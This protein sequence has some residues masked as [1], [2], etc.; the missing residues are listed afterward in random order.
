MSDS[1][2]NFS[3]APYY[4]IKVVHDDKGVMLQINGRGEV[5]GMDVQVPKK[6]LE[7]LGVRSADEI[8]IK[9]KP[10]ACDTFPLGPGDGS[11]PNI[12]FA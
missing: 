4:C 11:L 8:D 6:V 2:D 7:A 3:C 9:W 10:Y 1:E 5:S 12:S